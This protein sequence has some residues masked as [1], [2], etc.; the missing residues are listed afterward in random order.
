MN[1]KK[2]LRNQR[3]AFT[4]AEVVI[5]MAILS[6]MMVAFAPVVTK[7]SN[8]STDSFRTFQRAVGSH[9]IYYGTRRDMKPV[10]IG[11]NELRY[12]TGEGGYSPKLVIAATATGT[13]NSSMF[14]PHIGFLAEVRKADNNTKF[15]TGQL[16]VVGGY[17]YDT[18][19][20]EAPVNAVSMENYI[21]NLMP[22]AYADSKTS[23]DTDKDKENQTSP[24]PSTSP[25]PS[26]T[27]SDGSIGTYSNPADPDAPGP[28]GIT[29]VLGG[30][31]V[32]RYRLDAGKDRM[33]I[34]GGN[35]CAGATAGVNGLTCLGAD[36]AVGAT[37]GQ[38][39]VFVGN[40][41]GQNS[42]LGADSVN[43]GRNSGLNS[44]GGAE[45]VNIGLNAG[46][47]RTSGNHNVAI[48]S[49]AGASQSVSNAVFIGANAGQGKTANNNDIYIGNSAQ[50]IFPSRIFMGQWSLSDLVD[51]RICIKVV[52][53]S[54][55]AT[56]GGC[57]EPSSG[58]S[59]RPPGNEQT[60]QPQSPLGDRVQ[61][62]LL[63]GSDSAI[64]SD[65]RLKNVGKPYTTGLDLI[66]KIMPVNFTY[67]RD[68]NKLPHVGVVAQELIKI[69][70]NA[71]NANKDGYLYIRTEDMF[72]AAINSIKE[73]HQMFLEHDKRIKQLEA[74]NAVLEQQ[75]K[76]LMELYTELAK[77]V[78]HLDKKKT[79]DVK[80]TQMPEVKEETP[81]ETEE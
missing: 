17:Q 18:A 33:T 71:V 51:Q 4:L 21:P 3:K 11:D 8:T 80:F 38:N 43:I 76:E 25:S 12:N 47:G 9:G 30:N 59:T 35:A 42:S 15:A 53:G 79:K 58:S 37:L 5:V 81:A 24:Q 46:S 60:M 44:Q 57:I 56:T 26:V 16:L 78:E 68:E 75:N 55:D 77:R 50:K 49:S 66:E 41:A 10:V 19:V 63:T 64:P 6:I 40:S 67:K 45:D 48:G 69:L 32:A 36:T 2:F 73:L 20:I 23:T 1:F 62:A 29:V 27:P 39:S 34:I 14:T 31:P 28:D 13:S 54:V 72:Y 61:V 74:R 70:P 65:E 7:K 52:G 22:V